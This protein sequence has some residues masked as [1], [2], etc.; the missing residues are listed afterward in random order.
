MEYLLPHRN[1][2]WLAPINQMMDWNAWMFL[3]WY[4][5]PMRIIQKGDDMDQFISQFSLNGIKSFNICRK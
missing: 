3:Q 4:Y 5:L 1:D 2:F